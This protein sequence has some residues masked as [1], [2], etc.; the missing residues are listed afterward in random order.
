MS[1]VR[2]QSQMSSFSVHSSVDVGRHLF[3]LHLHV[4]VLKIINV[5]WCQ[6]RNFRCK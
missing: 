1:L 4:E 2:Q 3:I 5:V 6:F